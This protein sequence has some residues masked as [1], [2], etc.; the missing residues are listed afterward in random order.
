LTDPAAAAGFRSLFR[1]V[2][3][4][5]GGNSEIEAAEKLLILLERLIRQH[6]GER[7]LNVPSAIKQ[8]R[9]RI[10]DDPVSQLSLNELAAIGG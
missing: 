6:S 3:D 4:K 5:N 8:A 10:D 9:S 1:A 2:T 7:E